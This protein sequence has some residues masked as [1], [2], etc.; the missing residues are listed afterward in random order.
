MIV[1]HMARQ[2]R[3]NGEDSDVPVS[4]GEEIQY[5]LSDLIGNRDVAKSTAEWISAKAKTVPLEPDN[6]KLSLW[7]GFGFGLAI[8]VGI[9]LLRI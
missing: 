2:S 8:F 1:A 3:E 6:V 5:A 4:G 7:L 9:C